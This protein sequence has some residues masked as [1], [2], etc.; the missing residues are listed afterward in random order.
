MS[1]DPVRAAKVLQPIGRRT[2]KVLH[3][4]LV[5]PRP[6]SCPEDRRAAT[7]NHEKQFQ[8]CCVV[9]RSGAVSKRSKIR[10]E[11]GLRP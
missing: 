8:R 3:T 5:S 6:R 2:A 10:S 9:L 11:S 7:P 4:L 1:E